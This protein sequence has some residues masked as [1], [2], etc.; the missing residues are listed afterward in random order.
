MNVDFLGAVLL[1]LLSTL[2]KYMRKV[3]IHEKSICTVN[4]LWGGGGGGGE[5]GA[6]FLGGSFRVC[7]GGGDGGCSFPDVKMAAMVAILKIYFL[8][9]LN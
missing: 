7:G 8:H 3:H 4:P 5:G 6:D 9:L 1:L 2:F